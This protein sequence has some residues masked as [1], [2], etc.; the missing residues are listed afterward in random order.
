MIMPAVHNY[1][2]QHV[3]FIYA[4]NTLLIF[5]ISHAYIILSV[6]NG[7]RARLQIQDMCAYVGLS[8]T[9]RVLP[10]S[11]LTCPPDPGWYISDIG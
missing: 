10:I 3:S 7:M 8:L 1:N 4:S 9:G 6:L 5:V 11:A 2:K